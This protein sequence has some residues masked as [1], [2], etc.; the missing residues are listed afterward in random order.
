MK[1]FF[2][3]MLKFHFIIPNKFIKKLLIVKVNIFNS[4]GF[5]NVCLAKVKKVGK[6]L[7]LWCFF[8]INF[9]LCVL[10]TKNYKNN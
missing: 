5:L 2:E 3:K 7:K 9:I 10:I 6:T 8:T 4:I 1:C